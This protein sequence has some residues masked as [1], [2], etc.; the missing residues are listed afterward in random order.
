MTDTPINLDTQRGMAAQRATELRRLLA[1]V[2]A[3][4]A[5][6]RTRQNELEGQLIAAPALTWLEA[7]TKVRYLLRI[8]MASPAG[9]DSRHRKLVDAVL[10]DFERLS[11]DPTHERL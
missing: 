8:L 2:E 1:E 5:H 7:A 11:K 6:L 10:A 4:E 9:L 3:N